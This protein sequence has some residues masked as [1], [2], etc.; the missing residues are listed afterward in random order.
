LIV[1]FLS[2][3]TPC[4][5]ATV[6]GK[7]RS[8]TR[9]LSDAKVVVFH[10]MAMIFLQRGVSDRNGQYV[11]NL[12]PGPYRIWVMKEG[13]VP[14]KVEVTIIDRD[15]EVDLDHNLVVNKTSPERQATQTLKKFLRDRNK[16]PY[17]T[18]NGPELIDPGY[19]P[20]V[21]QSIV[22]TVTSQTRQGIEG[23]TGQSSTVEVATWLND[24]VRV[25]SRLINERY[26]DTAGDTME[27]QAGVSME[28]RSLGLDVR[29]ESIQSVEEE[30]QLNGSSKFLQITGH[31]EQDFMTRTSL[32]Y[33]SS[34]DGS[35]DQEEVSLAQHLDYAFGD[36]A[37]SHEITLTGWQQNDDV[38]AQRALVATSWKH[39]PESILGLRTDLD[40]ISLERERT[41]ISKLWMTG[42]HETDTLRFHSRLGVQHQEETSGLVQ[43]HQVSSEFGN[44]QVSAK[45][46]EDTGIQPFSSRDVF[47]VYLPRPVTPHANESF[48]RSPSREAVLSLGYAHYGGWSS[49]VDWAD[50]RDNAHL[51]QARNDNT[52]RSH[53]RQD[54]H[55][56]AYSL[57]SD[58]WGS[59]LELNHGRNESEET[60][61]TS[62]GVR[63]TQLLNPFRGKGPG[64]FVELQMTNHPAIPEW[65][66]LEEL[67][68]DPGIDNTWYQGHLSL[69]F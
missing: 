50:S 68:W 64:I 2:A 40:T 14:R 1:L 30:S 24:Q 21:D 41:T 62:T 52:F 65:W 32:S 16:D 5:G 8:D 23:G 45:Y 25:D 69:Q 49:R 33:R 7:I 29:A 27:I 55:Y 36:Q 13:F 58:R 56:Y 37:L 35:F 31:Y 66:L 15:Q 48:Y 28:L 11:F 43:Y 38:L 3:L 39:R 10:Q 59:R 26:A 67:P 44:V 18:L 53:A 20:V 51:L 61:F 19:A 12:E 42:E 60:S 46:I 57:S 17:R 34:E 22:G 54:A 47:G 63:Y 9:P 4:F 6:A